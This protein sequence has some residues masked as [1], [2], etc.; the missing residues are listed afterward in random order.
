MRR[1]LEVAMKA[2]PDAKLRADASDVDRAIAEIRAQLAE[3]HNQRI[4]VDIDEAT[5]LAQVEILRERLAQIARESP[6]VQVRTDTAAAVAELTGVEA[7]AREVGSLD[8]TINVKTRGAAE[9]AASL[10]TLAFAAERSFSSTGALIAA[11][12]SL[13]TILVPAAAAA[14]V[15]IGA[16][17]TAAG[18][19]ATGVGVF[20]LS[21]SGIGG[22]VQAL[23][24]Y[25][26]QAQKSGVSLAQSQ[27]RVASAM[28]SV[29]SAQR[30]LVRA[31]QE[32]RDALNGLAQAREE[33]RRQQQDMAASIRDNLLAQRQAQLDVKK[34]KEELDKLLAN[35]RA[36][37]DELE[38]ARV[39]YEEKANQ[40]SDLKV[41][42]DR[43]AAD[44]AKADK[45]GIDGSAQ[46]V[47]AQKRIQ[48]A[49][50]AVAQ[51]HQSVVSANRNV[52]QS[53]A[54]A[55]VAG[56][57]ALTN[58]QSAMA[59]LTPT[60]RRFATFIFGLKGQFLDLRAAA[61]AGV[62]PGLQ[63]AIEQVLPY[64]P[65]LKKFV[66]DVA[67]E[68][69]LLAVRFVQG[70]K[71]P[72][73]QRFFGFIQQTA[74]PAMRGLFEFSQN[75][76][77]G[78]A[79]VFLAL[80]PFNYSIGS[81]LLSLSEGF[82]HW[83]ETLGSNQGYRRFLAY[84]VENGPKVVDLIKDMFVFVGRFVVAAAPVGSFILGA[85][86]RLF[87]LL[88]AIP[89]H[90][91]TLLA[92]AL[93]AVTTAVL[94]AVGA[95]KLFNVVGKATEII[96]KR[97]AEAKKG[98]AGAVDTYRNSLDRATT[99]TAA[100]GR[101]QQAS[102]TDM[103]ISRGGFL[104]YGTATEQ[105]TTKVGFFTR[106]MSGAR[107]AGGL[108]KTG[109]GSLV[110]FLG[111]PWGIALTLASLGILKLYNSIQEGKARISGITDAL[112]EYGNALKDGVTS[113]SLK[114]AQAILQQHKEL[115]G[116]VAAAQKAGIS[117]DTVIKA[118]TGDRAARDQLIGAIHA[119]EDASYK[120]AY[121]GD[122][123]NKSA[124][125]QGKALG[126]LRKGL[127]GLGIDE[128]EAGRLANALAGEVNDTGLSF[129]GAAN[130]AVSHAH[131]T[132]LADEKTK[133]LV[134]SLHTM[135][136][137]TAT[138]IDR[139]A[140]YRDVLQQVTAAAQEQ[141]DKTLAAAEANLQASQAIL[142]LKNNKDGLSRS[143]LAHAHALD[144]TTQAAI[145]QERALTSTASSYRDQYLAELASG[146]YT[147]QEAYKRF[148]DRI[149]AL[150]TEYDKAGY[151]KQRVGEL[152]ATYGQVPS[153][154]RTAF[155]QE[156]FP[157]TIEGLAGLIRQIAY[158]QFAAGTISYD[159]YKKR[160]AQATNEAQ[161]DI[162]KDRNPNRLFHAA[163]GLITGPGTTT[164]DSIPAWLSNREYVQPAHAVDYYGA[165]W[166][167]AV[168]QHAIPR[169]A[170]RGMLA[171]DWLGAQF[172]KGGLV[173][174][175]LV[176]DASKVLN[177][178]QFGSSL[179][180]GGG[181]LGTEQGQRGWQWQINVLRQAFPGLALLSGFRPGA[182]TITGNTSY[183][184][185]GRAVDVPPR[186]DVFN[187]IRSHY[188]ASTKELIFTPEGDRQVWNG[189]PHVFSG[190]VAREHYSHIH[191]AYDDGGYLPPGVST[192][193][194]GT[195]RPEPVLTSQQ[196]TDV[197]RVAEFAA[198]KPGLVHQN[199]FNFRDTT[200]TAGRLQAIQDRQAIQAR[201]GRAR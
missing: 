30:S 177:L 38:Q 170:A 78:L 9:S 54:S 114:S 91:L 110:G 124:A 183:H 191:W 52:A 196:M 144:R 189:K 132:E 79:G 53:Y 3:L 103:A 127:Q 96:T 131:A 89:L 71:D 94:L 152:I 8:P 24:K 135:G 90:D 45:A 34:A 192:V 141:E 19:A 13:G 158:A 119:Q 92:A 43:L 123:V 172:A 70:F 188:G 51:A 61:Q 17:G 58:L 111:G 69:G 102:Y 56:G 72:V 85:F 148:Q 60:G 150:Q 39:S 21:L 83:A 5:A 194:N 140:A 27:N 18:A 20:A 149:T 161:F 120:L 176:V 55:D 180:G 74:V 25:Q 10:N 40:L 173:T 93:A 16:I 185:L 121:S 171:G 73:W 201:L 35:P 80:T 195:G 126:D 88:N 137:R 37:Q 146:K 81:G 156:N 166:M 12:V 193:F 130:A 164:S 26:D 6:S 175:P 95:G 49:T 133:S 108:L 178:G 174:L 115:N 4:G 33:A 157:N 101:A 22:A 82:A 116:L 154:V 1:R 143:E 190:P 106:A 147:E 32:E 64:F 2:L 186:D 50:D 142:D 76:A 62:L 15:A 11:G 151:D 179:Q 109:L 23:N 7:M 84:V 113:E 46:V 117:Q 48:S 29:H 42:Q 75:V 59:N 65:T 99:S 122:V 87:H 165:D 198:S 98:L 68:M 36:S 128:D 181:T 139:V 145:D 31:E 187:W 136:D 200:L 66:G 57:A 41:K 162:E 182:I 134:V 63:T 125:N 167:E 77:K 86:T 105:T 159:E 138:L 14:A 163:G 112:R 184:A 169:D 100:L 199:T 168:R 160:A 28:D 107:A 155:T 67:S 129:Y 104:A 97:W 153:E 118:L 44:K 47:A 197:Q